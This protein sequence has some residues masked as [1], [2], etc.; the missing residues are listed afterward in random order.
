[1]RSCLLLA[2]TLLLAPLVLAGT[3]QAP[4]ITDGTND[5]QPD[6]AAGVCTARGAPEIDVVRAWF[7]PGPDVVSVSVEVVDLSHRAFDGE[8]FSLDV[9]FH[10]GT[11]AFTL[12][13]AL[14][15]GPADNFSALFVDHADGTSEGHAIRWSTSGNVVTAEIPRAYL[16]GSALTHVRASGRLSQPGVLGFYVVGMPWFCD[17][18][19]D[20]GYGQDVP[21]G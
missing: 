13:N 8:G 11:D 17:T 5:V 3:Q 12:W 1:M 21:L 10:S 15:P 9:G 6:S 14:G 20:V 16:P 7:D 19:P 2:A 4:E 18:A